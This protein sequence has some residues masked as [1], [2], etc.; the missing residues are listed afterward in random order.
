MHAYCV[1]T[2]D[3]AGFSFYTLHIDKYKSDKVQ[4]KTKGEEG[5]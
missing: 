1:Y 4:Y 5:G 3:P 2:E